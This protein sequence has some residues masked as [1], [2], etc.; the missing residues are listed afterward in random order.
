M[1]RWLRQLTQGPH[2]NSCK[3]QTTVVSTSTVLHPSVVVKDVGEKSSRSPA[4]LSH[5]TFS[6]QNRKQTEVTHVHTVWKH[7][8][9][10]PGVPATNAP[11]VAVH[12]VPAHLTQ[13]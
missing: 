9:C 12:F 8:P 11:P 4:D 6:Y 3:T 1:I 13:D 2:L 5:M 10:A 7:Y